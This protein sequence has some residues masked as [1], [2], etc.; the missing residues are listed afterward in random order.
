MPMVEEQALHYEPKM[1][2]LCSCFT[3]LLLRDWLSEPAV[4]RANEPQTLARR[5]IAL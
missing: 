1:I 3:P 4:P 5:G 2:M